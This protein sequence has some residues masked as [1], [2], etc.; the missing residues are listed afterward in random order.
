MTQSRERASRYMDPSR[1]SVRSCRPIPLNSTCKKRKPAD[2]NALLVEIIAPLRRSGSHDS[3]NPLEQG[4]SRHDAS[5]TRSLLFSRYD[6]AV[7]PSL[8]GLAREEAKHSIVKRGSPRLSKPH[9]Q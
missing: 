4:G 2:S 7:C 1:R 5:G 6:E 9:E 8:Y 3:I